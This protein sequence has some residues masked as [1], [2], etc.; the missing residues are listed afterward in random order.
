MAELVAEIYDRCEGRLLP[1][2]GKPVG[3]A[4]L[5][6]LFFLVIRSSESFPVNLSTKNLL[7]AISIFFCPKL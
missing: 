2:G 4:V 1:A 6:L 7:L 3:K 5:G